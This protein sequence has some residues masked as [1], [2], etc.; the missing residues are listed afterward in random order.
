M[1][2]PSLNARQLID[3]LSTAVL[4]LDDRFRVLDMNPAAESLLEMSASRLARQPFTELFIEAP[5]IQSNLAECLARGTSFT[6]REVRLGTLQGESCIC[7]ISISLLAGRLSTRLLVEIQPVSRMEL[8]RKDNARLHDQDTAQSM[9]RGMAH[10]IKNPLGGILGAAQLL[11]R[12]LPESQREYTR[13]IIEE[14][15]RLRAL[16][17]DMLGP[18]VPPKLARCNIHQ[19]LER[20][21]QLIAIEA[22]EMKTLRRDYDPSIPDFYM[23]ND[24]VL[25][26]V[27]NVSRNAMQALA[28]H[29]P[30]PDSAALSFRTRVARNFTIGDISHKLVCEITIEDNGPGIPPD[31]Q[32]RIFY[33]MISCRPE[34]TGLGLHIANSMIKQHGGL[35]NC[36]SE[37]GRTA[38][39]IML[40]IQLQKESH[41]NGR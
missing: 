1:R 31:L 13:I 24:R 6:N 15:G 11:E 2:L 17:D 20:V 41:Q 32:D 10:E 28:S 3:A 35:I 14:T 12:E 16:V 38:F 8:I 30:T 33:P 19:V 29:H 7:D 22:P 26:A 25:Q 9:V 40:P 18:N 5:G 4:V 37:P 34:G 21:L 36:D 39:R 23:D 27:L